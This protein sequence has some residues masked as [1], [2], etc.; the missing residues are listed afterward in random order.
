MYPVLSDAECC[1]MCRPVG[2]LTL[3]YILNSL[4]LTS[5]EDVLS[6]VLPQK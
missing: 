1:S 5:C 3:H 6:K 2:L 4:N